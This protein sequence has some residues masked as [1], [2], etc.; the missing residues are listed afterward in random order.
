MDRAML[1]KAIDEHFTLDELKTL[2]F[3]LHV[4]YEN[5]DG[6]TRQ[7]KVRELVAYCERVGLVGALLDA[8]RAMRPNLDLKEVA[9]AEPDPPVI[10]TEEQDTI[11]MD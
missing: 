3:D 10:H 7:A 6:G 8:V 4:E 9:D 2:C 5:L 1:R 11:D